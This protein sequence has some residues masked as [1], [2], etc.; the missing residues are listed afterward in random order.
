MIMRADLFWISKGGSLSIIPY[1][2]RMLY[3]SISIRPGTVFFKSDVGQV[4]IIAHSGGDGQPVEEDTNGIQGHPEE[5]SAAHIF[6]NFLNLWI[7]KVQRGLTPLGI[8][9]RR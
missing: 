3:R 6:Y 9:G 4:D 8:K 5:G 2:T 7:P 1:I